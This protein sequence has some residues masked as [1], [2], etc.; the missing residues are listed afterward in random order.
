MRA[1]KYPILDFDPAPE[2]IIEPSRLYEKSGL[3]RLAVLSFFQDVLQ[4]L[5]NEQMI[6]PID[7][8]VSE[9]GRNSVYS[10]THQGREITV[11]HPGVGAPLAAAFLEELIAKGC[12]DFIACGAC[13]VLHKEI[14]VGH[15][16]VIDAA[17]RDEGTSNAYCPPGDTI[18]PNPEAT[19][20]IE[21]TLTNLGVPYHKVKTWTTDAIYRET[22]ERTR[23]RRRQGCSI[24]EMEAAAFFAV[25]A[26]RKVRF[27]QLVYGGDS[28]QEDG[29]DH[30]DWH[31]RASIREKL[32][33]LAVE[34]VCSLSEY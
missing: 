1:H 29:W 34:S 20:S 13:G 22:V 9:I 30:R 2:A 10:L 16:L 26:F 18:R 19:T 15:L 8:L 33:W 11:C 14:A 28:V 6:K 27:G 25:A 7:H 32:F 17:L 4:K 5:S 3:P 21:K 31:K 24:V 12:Q 23:L